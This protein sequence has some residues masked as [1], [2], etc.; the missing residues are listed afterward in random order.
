[1]CPVGV[2]RVIFTRKRTRD[3]LQTADVSTYSEH[4]SCLNENYL[5]GA[6][7]NNYVKKKKDAFG[8]LYSASF[9][10][11]SVSESLKRAMQCCF[12]PLG[13]PA[14]SLLHLYIQLKLFHLTRH[15]AAHKLAEPSLLC[16]SEQLRRIAALHTGTFAPFPTFQLLH[17]VSREYDAECEKRSCR[18]FCFFKEP[19]YLR[20]CPQ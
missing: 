3:A 11:E 17:G 8:H 12:S 14:L 5:L 19:L 4:C 1:M 16:V 15:L 6:F 9:S 7:K 18:V 13:G 2:L 20:L 10:L